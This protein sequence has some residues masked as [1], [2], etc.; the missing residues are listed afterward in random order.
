MVLLIDT[1][2]ANLVARIIEKLARWFWV[3]FKSQKK[4]SNKLSARK[5]LK[6]A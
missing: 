1:I 3:Y 4:E 5:R 6:F 2:I